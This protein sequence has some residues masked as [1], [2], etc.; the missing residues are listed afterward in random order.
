MGTY[1]IEVYR[2]ADDVAPFEIWID[3]L[4]DQKVKTRLAARLFRVQSGNLG[5][6]KEIAGTKGLFEIREHF[7][8][9][10][11][12]F[13]SIVDRKIVLLLAGSTKQDQDRVIS[14]ARE[15]LADYRQRK[16]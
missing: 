16:Q 8:P 7:G 1:E 6:W 14:R 15:Y 9:G 10:Y 3:G 13:F 5:D 11:R 4:R 12:L 2:T